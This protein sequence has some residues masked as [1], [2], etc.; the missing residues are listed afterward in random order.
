MASKHRSDGSHLRVASKLPDGRPQSGGLA[1]KRRVAM[2]IRSLNYGGAETQ[3]TL[4]ANGLAESGYSVS[5]LVMYQGGPLLARLSPA[6]KVRCL[7]KRGRW[8]LAGFLRRLSS[9]LEEEKPDLLYAFMPVANLL[10]CVAK[11]RLP[12]LRVTWGVR[13][14]DVDLA[15]YDWLSRLTYWL[16]R[17]FS[18]FPDLIV[19]NSAAGRRYAMAQGFPAN[20]RFIVIPNGT[21]VECFRPCPML[22]EA[23]RAEWG[24]SPNETLV[25]VVGRLDPVKD[26]PT[27][28]EAAALL[29]RRK[30]GMRFV[31]VGAGPP[32]YAA[33]LRQQACRLGLEGKM[34]WAGVRGDMPA[35]YN[36][37]DLLVSSSFGEGFS[38][39]L[40][41]GMACGVPC[42][43]TDV[44]D[45]REILGDV[46]IVVPRRDPKALAAGITALLDRLSIERA[47]LCASVRQQISENF[48]VDT[49]V[50]RTKAALE[51]IP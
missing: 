24:L 23:V 3:M 39:A 26:Y 47:S 49:L 51:A 20:G 9:V 1:G 37:L 35:A 8:D 13:A 21:D 27:F 43:A 45:A 34:I 42:V 32:E 22:R 28:L 18:R 6:V 41:E 40:A 38:N 33:H 4:L 14:S 11:V 25:G 10:A 31:S 2:L 36:A 5:L 46:G 15:H 12:K 17:R 50:A 29:A 30:E 7:E 19:S 16:E 48:S 44:G